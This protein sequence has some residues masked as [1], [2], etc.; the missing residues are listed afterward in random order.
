[1]A[2]LTNEKE[3]KRFTF[4]RKVTLGK[5]PCCDTNVFDNELYVEDNG[6]IYHY[7][8]YNEKNKEQEV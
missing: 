7:A 6:S 8:C 3:T 1:M 2:T 5:C 4:E